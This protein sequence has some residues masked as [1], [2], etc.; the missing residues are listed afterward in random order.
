[1]K[2][3]IVLVTFNRIDD[4]KKTLLAYDSQIVK[5]QFV[6]VVDNNSTDGTKEYLNEWEKQSSEFCHYVL[7]L[8]ENIGGSGGFYMGM[9]EALNHQCDWI[10]VADDDAVPH[11]AMLKELVDFSN[12]HMEEMDQISA[13]CT[14]VNN[15]G[16]CSGIHR[17]RIRKSI[18]GYFESYVSEEE[19]EKEYFE[20]DIYSFVGTMIRKSA[21][22]KAGLARK[23]FF[24]YNDDYEHAVR[25]GKTGR[26]ICVPKAIM[27]HVDNLNYSREATWRDYYAT[28]N[29]II[30]HLEHFGVY[31]GLVRALRRLAV[32]I[33]SLNFQ[34]IKVICIGIKDGFIG[35]T[36]IHACYKPGWKVS[37]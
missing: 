36:G 24:I 7:S 21:L 15:K 30:M 32:G 8:S 13:L 16:K 4:L 35:K 19:Y 14:S 2:V 12:T 34:K 1:M 33:V 37:K 17:C 10:F 3:G 28:R 22:E 9:K 29:G 25:V 27:Y 26:I 23:E 6:L 20:I 18:L 5:P 11:K 31:A